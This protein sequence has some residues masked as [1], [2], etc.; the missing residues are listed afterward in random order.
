MFDLCFRQTSRSS[1]WPHVSELDPF[2]LGTLEGCGT[3]ADAF[4][5]RKMFVP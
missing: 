3:F 2:G 1:K 5:L 4:Q